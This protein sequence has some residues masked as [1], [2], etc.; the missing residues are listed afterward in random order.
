MIPD[1]TPSELL[2]EE[3][4]KEHGKDLVDYVNRCFYLRSWN[5]L[6]GDYPY[7]LDYDRLRSLLAIDQEFGLR[8]AFDSYK[9]KEKQ[10]EAEQQIKVQQAQAKSG[11]GGGARRTF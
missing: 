9:M 4:V 6:H 2:T 3:L 1:K 11:G 5:A 10:R 7:E 8:Q